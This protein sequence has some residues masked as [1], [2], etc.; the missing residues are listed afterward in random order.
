MPAK[1]E[2][3]KPVVLPRLCKGCG[4]CIEACPRDCITL[5]QEI[6]Q[7]SGLIPVVIDLEVCN[8]CGLCITACPEPYGLAT[9]EYE[10]E[11]PRQLYG[12]REVPRPEVEPV[13]EREIPLPACEPLAIKGNH[14]AAVG[15]LLA[16]CRHVFGYPITPSTEGAEAMASLLPKIN[17]VFLQAVSEVATVNHMYGCGG[18][19]LPCMTFTS[20][21]GFSLML[22]GISYMI[23]SC[24]PAVFV[25]VMRGGPGLGNIAPAQADISLC[26]RGLGHGDTHAIV[27]AP[28]TPQEMLDLTQEAFRLSFEYRNPVIVL[29]DGY[30][31]QMTGKVKLPETMIEPG[32]PSWAVWGDAAHRQN[33]HSSI[34]LCEPEFEQHNE[35]LQ[36][37]YRAMTDREQRAQLFRTD[38]A[39]LLVV[40]CNTPARMAK[41]AVETLRARGVSVGLFH[42]MTLWPFPINFLRPLLDHVTDILVVEASAGQLEDELRLALSLAEAPPVAIHGLRHMGGILPQE[43]EIVDRVLAIGEAAR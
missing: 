32:I 20:S 6:N 12:E 2:R 16:G 25:N 7:D 9:N 11:D 29:A 18:A 10:L 1:T 34:N 42:P 28:T 23:G 21:P 31:G 8:G 13:P 40:S 3:P 17:G 26:C 14:A 43:Q 33:L 38:G 22:E 30:L 15:A 24:L 39:S 19:G 27:L 35:K 4:R 41:G 36:A 37:K 5:G